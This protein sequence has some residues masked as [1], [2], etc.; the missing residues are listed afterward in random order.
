MK[1]LKNGLYKVVGFDSK[2]KRICNWNGTKI[3][4][5]VYIRKME[6]T[7]ECAMCGR[8]IKGYSFDSGFEC[9]IGPSCIEHIKLEPVV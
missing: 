8:I 4:D 1:E 9:T 2:G 5:E 7:C 3:G 6:D